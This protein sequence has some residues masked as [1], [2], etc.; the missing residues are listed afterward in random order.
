MEKKNV[1]KKKKHRETETRQM[2][3]IPDKFKVT[4]LQA[5]TKNNYF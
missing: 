1:K 4:L 5:S 3:S 2:L